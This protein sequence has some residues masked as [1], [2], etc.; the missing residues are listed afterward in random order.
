[1]N[2]LDQGANLLD[3]GATGKGVARGWGCSAAAGVVL[4]AKGAAGVLGGGALAARGR[5]VGCAGVGF[6]LL[7][8]SS[9]GSGVSTG[10]PFGACDYSLLSTNLIANARY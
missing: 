5:G 9:C 2:P 4:G 8:F 10:P 7:G 3:L 6:G 1:M